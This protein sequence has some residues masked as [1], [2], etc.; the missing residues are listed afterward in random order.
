MDF[1]RDALTTIKN[2]KQKIESLENEKNE[3]I[4]IVGIGC[5]YPGD[6]DDPDSFWNVVENATDAVTDV[7]KSRWDADALYD[8]DPA[9][10]GKVVSRSGGFVPDIDQFDADFFGISP[11]EAVSLDPQQ[12]LLL[13]TCWKALEDAGIPPDSIVNSKTGVFIGQSGQEYWTLAVEGGLDKLDGYVATGSSSSVTSGRLSYTLGLKGPSLTLDTACSSSLVSIHM[14]CQSLRNNESSMA[15]VGGVTVMVSPVFWV[16]FSRL[17]GLA[18]DGR[19][20]TF[21]AE[22]DGTGWA[23]G[24]GVVVLK[25]LSDALRDEDRIWAVIRGTAVNQDGRSNGLTAPN[26][27]AQEAVVHAALRQAGIKPAEV[28]YVEC[29]GTGTRLGDPIEV[30]ALG[31]VLA[32]GRSADNPVILGSVKSNI[33]HTQAA[34]GVA[35]LIK[36]V[37]AMQHQS[38]P[39]NLHFTTPNPLIPWDTLPVKVADKAIPWPAGDK[40][41]IAGV[42]AFGWSGTNAHIVLEEAPRAAMATSEREMTPCPAQLLVLSGRT[43]SAARAGAAQLAEH[44]RVNPELSLRDIAW[45]LATTRM[46]HEYRLALVASDRETAERQL[47]QVAH[48]EVVEGT[49]GG[50]ARGQGR[51]AWL[52]T[53]QGSQR[54]GMGKELWAH[55]PVFRQEFD[56][57][58]EALERHL[59]GDLKAVMWGEDESLLAETRWT[60]PALFALQAGLAALWRSWGQKPEYVA[61]HS[62]GELSAAYVAGVFT[63]EDAARL[64][65]ARGR[66]MQALPTGGSMAALGVAESE[67]SALTEGIEVAIAAVNGP[68]SVVVSGRSESVRMVMQRCAGRGI[69]VTELAV[70]HAFHSAEMAAMLP[71]FRDV[72]ESV[73]YASPKLK[74]VSNVSGAVAD[75]AICTAEY[76]VTHVMETVRFADGVNALQ[77]EGVRDFIELGP[78]GTLLGM[79][80]ACLDEQQ[81]DVALVA[82][83]Q[84]KQGEIAAILGSVGK[85]HVRGAQ[86]LWSEVFSGGEQRV[87][88]PLYAWQRQRYWIAPTPK[89][90]AGEETGHPLLGRQISL[91]GEGGVYEALITPAK[92]SWLYDHIVGELAVVPGAGI[93]ELVRAAGE[94]Y[95]SRPDVSVSSLI[96]QSPLILAEDGQYIQVMINNRDGLYE[97]KVWSRQAQKAEWQLNAI[98]E[99]AGDIAFVAPLDLT[100][101]KSRC[102]T[103]SDISEVYQRFAELGLPY[104]PAFRG[105]QE[106]WSN[107]NEVLASLKVPDELNDISAFGIHP[108]LLDSAFQAYLSVNKSEVLQLP[109]SID[110]LVTYQ[111]TDKNVFAWVTVEKAKNNSITTNVV[112]CDSAGVILTEV[113]GLHGRPTY[114]ATFLSGHSIARSIYEVC[115]NTAPVSNNARQGRYLIVS[116]P[117]DATAENIAALLRE[118]S[119]DFEMVDFERLS[120][121]QYADNIV[122]IFSSICEEKAESWAPLLNALSVLKHIE[123]NKWDVRLCWVTQGAVAVNDGTFCDVAQY[124]LWGAGRTV[125]LEHPEYQCTLIDAGKDSDIRALVDAIMQDGDER[126]IA[127]TVQGQ[128]VP[129][130]KQAKDID[131]N[132]SLRSTGTILISGGLGA[133][134]KNIALKLAK[135]GATHL[136]L[137]GRRGQETPGAAEVVAELELAG[138]QVTVAELDI[139]DPQA[140]KQLLE[141]LPQEHPLQGVIHAAGVLDAGVLL[142]QTEEKLANVFAAKVQGAMNLDKLT[143]EY[144]IDLFVLFSSVEGTLGAAG[145]G[146][147]AAANACLDAIA[148]NRRSIGLAGQSLAW[149]LWTDDSSNPL[150]VA[151][152]LDA[153]QQARIEKIG[154]GIVKKSLGTELFES[155]VGCSKSRLLLAPID[156]EQLRVNFKNDIPYLWKELVKAKGNSASKNRRSHRQIDLATVRGTVRFN[157]IVDIVRNNIISVLALEEK[158]VHINRPLSELGLDSL[159]A[160]ELRNELR[161]STGKT[162][163]ATLAFDYPTIFDMATFI[164]E[165]FML[166]EPAEENRTGLKLT[167]KRTVFSQLNTPEKVTMRVFFFPYASGTAGSA[168]RLVK[169]FPDNYEV[170]ALNY[171]RNDGSDLDKFRGDIITEMCQ[172][173]DEPY[174]VVGHSMGVMFAYDAVRTLLEKKYHSPNYL[175]LSGYPPP[176]LYRKLKDKLDETG[177]EAFIQ[178]ISSTISRQDIPQDLIDDLNR[179]INLSLGMP[180]DSSVIDVPVIA[181]SGTKDP[182]VTK[183]E[184]EG[185]QD[186]TSSDFICDQITGR[187]H[188][189]FE[190]AGAKAFVDKIVLK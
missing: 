164:N 93:G 132:R 161:K 78:Q 94:I 38:I 17:R 103:Q 57:A 160:V 22:A 71:A 62:L 1:K 129:R 54:V 178:G 49:N 116:H 20:K 72:A 128:Y 100:A 65:A 168:L 88:L 77:N 99:V 32:E 187:H 82:S 157:A 156:V 140:V 146:G 154:I 113:K 45:S 102:E 76:W 83:L 131:G 142:E 19:C 60:Q 144:D 55:F 139:T 42:S 68:S 153:K 152:G 177:I 127:L 58:C 64:V 148:A 14:A 122:C 133:V 183:E 115:W 7:P 162:L 4:A 34:A 110:S 151:S 165:Q 5:R 121:A 97:V 141:Q 87:P 48:G 40:S 90:L 28:D 67:I 23:E 107:E 61:G 117:G 59:G 169:Y 119:I 185:W 149:G 118:K 114:P 190:E 176:K 81:E 112:I 124:G 41:R 172:Y 8:P 11:R 35:G 70:S 52:F 134:G 137:T 43:E 47:R 6:I 29:H 188:Y 53:G 2:M 175:V 46:H 158:D 33:G 173:A 159:T 155:V 30:Q 89:A 66:L 31:S 27:P 92:H 10:L 12:R 56:A 79:V 21:S 75:E 9:V 170:H 166:S 101:I 120:V 98:A 84:R 111:K 3:P 44:L 145:Q 69:Q 138:A 85:L 123:Q 150:G 125:M 13:E 136:I 174:M 179:D 171:P 18:S 15:L 80:A 184:L 24:C 126:E 74:V 95:F 36:T 167:N 105:M 106:I 180:T 109:F 108:I 73:Q 130:L 186:I 51:S 104:G 189:W 143:R 96:L 37:L 163:P 39:Q 135:A 147:Y 25:R 182:L 86:I 16:E 26:G 91:A 181:L 63:L 50:M